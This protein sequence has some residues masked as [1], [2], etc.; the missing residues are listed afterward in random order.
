MRSLL[1]VLLVSYTSATVYQDCGSVGS[2]VQFSVEGCEAPPCLL[3]RGTTMNIGFQFISSAT[4]D[5]LTIDA[6]A[7]IGGVEVPW[8][9]IDTNGCLST[10]CP[11]S[12]GSSV[13][14]NMPVEI[15][16][17]YPAITTVVT[18]KLVD[19]SGASQTCALLPATLV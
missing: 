2:D 8:V 16:A 3:Y 11:I 1:L 10:T 15:L 18:F 19:S 4:T 7:N 12:A 9:G 6:T 5:T 17:E 14:W 13:D